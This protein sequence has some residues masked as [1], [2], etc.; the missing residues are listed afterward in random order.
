MGASEL[1]P[2]SV[3]DVEPPS[4]QHWVDGASGPRREG[5]RAGG[6]VG[7]AGWQLCCAGAVGGREGLV[8]LC[9]C[10]MLEKEELG[11]A[12]LPTLCPSWHS[13]QVHLP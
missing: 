8:V 7:L 1:L 10:G 2:Q 12:V 11:C 3:A 4:G 9:G 5:G 13:V 6:L